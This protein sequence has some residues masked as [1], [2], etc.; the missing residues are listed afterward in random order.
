[1]DVVSDATYSYAQK[2]EHMCGHTSFMTRCFPLNDSD[3]T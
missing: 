1:M 3:A 2:S